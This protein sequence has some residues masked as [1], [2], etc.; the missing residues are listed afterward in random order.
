MTSR[1]SLLVLA[2]ACGARSAPPPP[3]P[4]TPPTPPAATTPPATEDIAPQ[5]HTVEQLRDGSPRGRKIALRIELEGKPTTIER[6]EFTVVDAERATIHAITRDESGAVV[7]DQTG[8]STWSE[9]HAHAG[10]P[11]ASTTIE[12]SVSIT[13]PAGT[14]VTRLYTVQVGDATRRFWFA[15]DLPGPPVQFTTERGGKVVMRA[16]ML[17]AR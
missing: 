12:D 2:A 15:V 11:R 7:S 6:W 8:T 1:L 4:P 13:V 17:T 10:F 14:F 5:L 9:L 3:S 16:Q